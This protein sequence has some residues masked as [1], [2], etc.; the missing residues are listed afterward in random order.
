MDTDFGAAVALA[1][2][3]RYVLSGPQFSVHLGPSQ[4][5]YCVV[6]VTVI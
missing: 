3:Q 4:R 5:Q 1:V 2:P 6:A